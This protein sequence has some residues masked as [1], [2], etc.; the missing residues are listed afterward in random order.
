LWLVI[1]TFFLVRRLQTRIASIG[2]A[3]V[4]RAIWIGV[5]VIGLT[6]FDAPRQVC[7]AGRHAEVKKRERLYDRDAVLQKIV[8]GLRDKLFGKRARARVLQLPKQLKQESGV[9]KI[10]HATK[11]D[12][13]PLTDLFV[14]AFG[15]KE[16]G[17]DPDPFPKWF[18]RWGRRGWERSVR[19]E[20]R[21]LLPTTRGSRG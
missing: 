10:R 4:K 13:E 20:Y 15:K 2:E 1:A 14:R 21:Q 16:Q 3:S 18:C 17:K 19:R 12:I 7:L 5:T 8:F 9:P 11:A 6:A